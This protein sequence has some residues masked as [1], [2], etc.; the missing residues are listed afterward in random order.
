MLNFTMLQQLS[1]IP[2]VDVEGAYWTLFVELCFYV[3]MLALFS[4]GLLRHIEAVLLLALGVS[5][6]WWAGIA[7]GGEYFWSWHLTTSFGRV[8]PEIGFFAI[9]IGLYRLHA[10]ERRNLAILAILAILVILASLATILVQHPAEHLA[11][12]LVSIGAFG[13]ILTGRAGFLRQPV[14]VWLGAISYSLYLIH[15]FA[16][17]ALILRLQDD[18]GWSA[19]ASIAAALVASLVLATLLTWLVERPAQRLI[20]GW[21]AGWRGQAEPPR[22]LSVKAG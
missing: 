12:A 13:L 19:N 2:A 11:T 21:Y 1:I 4:L 5:L 17:R 18:A 8:F 14:L 20:R 7:H 10:G 15:N 16:G 9:G 6:A 22:R 3:A